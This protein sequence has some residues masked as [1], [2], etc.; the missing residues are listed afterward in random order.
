MAEHSKFNE[1]EIFVQLEFSGKSIIEN[2]KFKITN[3][4]DNDTLKYLHDVR[5]CIRLKHGHPTQVPKESPLYTDYSHEAIS[6]KKSINKRYNAF[7]QV[8]NWLAE[9]MHEIELLKNKKNSFSFNMNEKCLQKLPL[10]HQKLIELKS[11]DENTQLNH[12]LLCFQYLEAKIITPIIWIETLPMLIKLI[13][14]FQEKD[15]IRDYS[16]KQLN[17]CFDNHHRD[18]KY[19]RQMSKAID[20][21]RNKPDYSIDI[22]QEKKLVEVFELF[23]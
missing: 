12:F 21:L 4:D 14:R 10:L 9:K 16:A 15:I 23:N 7:C 6:I 18:K 5:D 3:L 20:K 17:L 19:G 1:D 8:E 11:I 13:I 2:I 22:E